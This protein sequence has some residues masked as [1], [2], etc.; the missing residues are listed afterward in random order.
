M[1]NK[2]FYLRKNFFK[3]TQPLYKLIIRASNYVIYP[4]PAPLPSANPQIKK[5]RFMHNTRNFLFTT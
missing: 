5:W 1:V 3:K 4:F 2:F